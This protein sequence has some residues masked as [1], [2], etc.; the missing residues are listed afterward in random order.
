MKNLS[1][2]GERWR[3]A[4][5]D[6]S[7]A[8]VD[9]CFSDDDSRVIL[10]S[11]GIVAKMRIDDSLEWSTNANNVCSEP[12]LKNSWF[13]LTA[14]DANGM[15]VVLN[16][17]NGA[18]VTL[19]PS[20][21]KAE[22]VGEF[23]NGIHAGAWSPDAEILLLLTM[24]EAQNATATQSLKSVL[25]SMNAQFEVLEEMPVED[26]LHQCHQSND[27]EQRQVDCGVSIAWRP[28]S[29]LVAVSYVD[30]CDKQRKVRM[31]QR[32]TLQYYAIGRI[33]DGSGKL[34]PN[35]QSPLAWAGI[36]CS[37]L[38]ASIQR[39]GTKTQ[40]VAFFEPNGLRHREFSLRE[41]P[42]NA[43]VLQ[44]NWNSH[45]DLLAVVLRCAH[46]DKVQLWHRSNYHWYLKKDLMF[47]DRKVVRAAF[48]PYQPYTIAV[49]FKPDHSFVE[50]DVRWDAA[51]I[52]Y[53]SSDCS[54]YVIDGQAL[55]ITPLGKALVP[56]PM[57]V[58]AH[59]FEQS[60]AQ[61]IPSRDEKF[62]YL[63]LVLLNNGSLAV[64]E[65]GRV[66]K[67]R[68]VFAPPVLR[69]VTQPNEALQ[70][71][72]HCCVVEENAATITFVAAIVPHG[73][74]ET[75]EYIVNV[76]ITV[77][78]DD[79]GKSVV[80]TTTKTDGRIIAIAPWLD[81]MD[82][83]LI[84]LENGSLLNYSRL[85]NESAWCLEH[86]LADPLLEPCLWISCL[87]D[88]SRYDDR[89]H[90][91]SKTLVVGMSSKSRLYCNDILLAE[92]VSSFCL[93]THQR[94]LCYASSGSQCQLR[95]L[96]FEELSNFDPLLGSYDN[97]CLIGFEPRNVE[98]DARIVA[99]VPDRPLAVVQMPR[100]N[101]E[102]LYPRALILRFVIFCIKQ[103]ELFNAFMMMRTHKVDLNLIVDL[104][105]SRFLEG[106]GAVELLSQVENVD[107]LNLFIS[108]L[109]NYDSTRGQFLIPDWLRGPDEGYT[110]SF[111]FRGK[112]TSCCRRLRS[113]MIDAELSG[114]T[115]SGKSI[116]KGYY[117]LPIL[118]TFAKEDPPKLSDALNLICERV[119]SISHPSSN[120]P[121]LFGEAAQSAIQYLA[122]LA[123]YEILFK[124]ALGMYN[125]DMARAIAR[126]SQM[127]PKEYLPLLKRYNELPKHY[128]KFEVD[129]RLQRYEQALKSLSIS[130][131]EG[132][133]L[134]RA[135]VDDVAD[136]PSVGNDFPQCM[137]LIKEHHMYGVALELFKDKK[138][139]S[140]ILVSLGDYLVQQKKFTAALAIFMNTDPCDYD[141]CKTTARLCRDWKSFF[142]IISRQ[143]AML[144]ETDV[145]RLQIMAHEI[146]DEFASASAGN[147]RRR[148]LL[149]DAATIALQ[150]GQDTML[151]VDIL[152]QGEMWSEAGRLAA[153]GGRADLTRRCV[154]AAVSFAK[155]TV[156]DLE[157]QGEIFGETL[158][159]Y[160]QVLKLRKESALGEGDATAE[161]DADDTNSLF[162]TASNASNLSMT[163]VASGESIGSLS[164]I[165]SINSTTS[166]SLT[167]SEEATRHKSKY[168]DQSG[169]KR[170][171]GKKKTRGRSA[172]VQPGS[173][174][175]LKGLVNTLH[176]TCVDEKSRDIIEE[177][178]FYLFREGELACA[179]ELYDG[180]MS[181]ATKIKLLQHTRLQETTG[182]K[183]L[184]EKER[185]RLGGLSTEELFHS[186]E[187]EVDSI[188]C[189]SLSESLHALFSFATASICGK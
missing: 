13:D 117:L 159:R 12:D 3:H 188:A 39:K 106:E 168:N 11:D 41:N 18:V 182:K 31:Y 187:L 138:Y 33:E 42:T 74:V 51:T 46:C 103:K 64:L 125:F 58:S 100:G 97:T 22:L 104:D 162:S 35:L 77:S 133:C 25:I 61:F 157:D 72:R 118:S 59:L 161:A 76:I 28:D 164:S 83:A 1:L 137:T 34:A 79:A 126:N 78:G 183:M 139:K 10:T 154:D 136:S 111:D 130:A 48:H 149:A 86:S 109:G 181:F 62:S 107:H 140:E 128:A 172:R 49:S 89:C 29:T 98:R 82:S 63:G 160:T 184:Q 165:I 147:E 186:S 70:F 146:A 75:D 44:L 19:D 16:H 40:Q 30:A 65:A 2:Q 102:G 173:E 101:L 175:E 36:G 73:T 174:Q 54:A 56:P 127:D 68:N 152:I 121:P 116:H 47:S 144:K 180:F 5:I 85:P 148:E 14:I 38:L 189:P 17:M 158:V 9:V 88:S 69:V 6:A 132:E 114:Q 131:A 177:S 155:T 122:F 27:A 8:I 24:T 91:E 81:T 90:S 163:S 4:P 166:F 45:S 92:A 167:G 7:G 26:H 110:D 113:L 176:S 43:V 99:I 57:F 185:Q 52:H 71:A 93:S 23:E 94:F 115:L 141:R 171:R 150:Y 53:S 120:T 80:K 66:G 145:S 37:L 55:N 153:L 143:N 20:T 96:A 170:D 15:L 156:A 151:A 95:F 119:T 84:E 32:D 135:H 50:Y 67:Q 112:V 21:G 134:D 105:P 60:I 87:R 142:Q 129:F 178:I 179:R 169:K 123:D 124:T 108:T